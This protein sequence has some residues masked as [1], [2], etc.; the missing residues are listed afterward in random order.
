MAFVN[1]NKLTA[2]GICGQFFWIYKYGFEGERE[3]TIAQLQRAGGFAGGGAARP[4]REAVPPGRGSARSVSQGHMCAPVAVAA[5][6]GIAG[7]CSAGCAC[8]REVYGA[9]VRPKSVDTFQCR[10]FCICC[11]TAQLPWVSINGNSSTWVSMYPGRASMYPGSRTEFFILREL[12]AESDFRRNIPI[13]PNSR[14][15]T[16]YAQV[17]CSA[18]ARA[19]ANLRGVV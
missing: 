16:R 13:G 12:G 3:A 15:Q 17:G 4:P 14:Y 19:R 8:T 11:Y 7:T 10:G 1:P 2:N 9:N 5:S 18:R 6:A